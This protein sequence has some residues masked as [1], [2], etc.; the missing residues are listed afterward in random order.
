MSD[1]KD[2]C[3][4][5]DTTMLVKIVQ[6]VKTE[7]TVLKLLNTI[8]LSLRFFLGGVLDGGGGGGRV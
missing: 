7:I 5:T 1:Y 3:S 4:C 6:H 8:S 2:H